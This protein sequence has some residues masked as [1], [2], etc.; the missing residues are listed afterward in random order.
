[1]AKPEPKTFVMDYTLF[2]FVTG[3]E[4]NTS[5]SGFASTSND[6]SNN[7]RQQQ[8]KDRFYMPGITGRFTEQIQR[9][10]L[11]WQKKD[12]KPETSMTKGSSGGSI[13]SGPA[14]QSSKIWQNTTFAQDTDGITALLFIYCCLKYF[15]FRKSGYE[16]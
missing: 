3:I 13:N 12:A 5:N 7:E 1:M 10:K 4:L 11:L 9:R 6:Q 14:V 15:F 8:E 2:N 16:I